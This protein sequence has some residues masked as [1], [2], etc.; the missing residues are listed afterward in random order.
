[1]AH[2][3]SSGHVLSGLIRIRCLHANLAHFHMALSVAICEKSARIDDYQ[4][5]TLEEDLININ[6]W[7][8]LFFFTVSTLY[9][10]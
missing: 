9:A 5:W 3:M 1:M 6:Y 7:I 8:V 2:K 10:S 4:E